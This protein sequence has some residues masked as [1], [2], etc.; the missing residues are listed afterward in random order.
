MSTNAMEQFDVSMPTDLSSARAKLVYFCLA[1]RGAATADE[2]CLALDLDKSTL[3]AI[4]ATLRDR[5]HV[6]RENGRYQLA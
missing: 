1:V 4:V 2:L 5:K 3:L 6:V